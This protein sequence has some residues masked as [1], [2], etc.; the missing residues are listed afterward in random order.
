MLARILDLFVARYRAA[1]TQA[2]AA[3]AAAA[4]CPLARGTRCYVLTPL[5]RRWCR[6]Y[7]P[8]LARLLARARAVAHGLARCALAQWVRAHALSPLRRFFAPQRTWAR[9]QARACRSAFN[10]QPLAAT[11]GWPLW[12][13]WRLARLAAG[14][15]GLRVPAWAC[16]LTF[17][18]SAWLS[19]AVGVGYALLVVWVYYYVRALRP[20]TWWD[21]LVVW[22]QA[23]I[24]G[25]AA[26][27]SMRLIL[28][29]IGW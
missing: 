28:L 29:C 1:A 8:L 18:T 17:G 3:R 22:T 2:R 20:V 4:A 27:L 19:V 6:T 15:W 12:C 21:V 24:V 7:A 10:P 11:A 9:Q 25:V 5:R 16:V 23:I 14:A 13:V 26:G